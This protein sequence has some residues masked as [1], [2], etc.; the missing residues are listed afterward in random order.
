MAST[1]QCHIALSGTKMVFKSWYLTGLRRMQGKGEDGEL[2]DLKGNFYL[3]LEVT[4][5]DG[6]FQRS[7]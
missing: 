1:S 7:C 2:K 4:V 6:S 3:R 5:L